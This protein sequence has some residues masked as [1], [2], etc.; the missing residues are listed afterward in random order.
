MTLAALAALFA[1]VGALA[2]EETVKPTQLGE[3]V[4]DDSPA[5][6]AHVV[7][8]TPSYVT[9]YV[10]PIGTHTNEPA[11]QGDIMYTRFFG[12]AGQHRA[13]VGLW[14]SV[15]DGFG[16]EWDAYAGAELATGTHSVLGL[17]V[18]LYNIE[19]VQVVPGTGD[20]IELGVRHLWKSGS[21][22]YGP[23]VRWLQPIDVPLRGAPIIYGEVSW[24]STD[25]APRTTLELRQR[26]GW[27]FGTYGFNQ[28]LL[29]NSRLTVAHAFDQYGATKASAYVDYS[30][31]INGTP[32]RGM[33]ISIGFAFSQSFGF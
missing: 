27:D 26:I 18:L 2:A 28:E 30:G 20:I 6:P 33:Y 11:I 4:A 5:M 1:S 32:P 24:T 16:N 29:S 12:S 8:V 19:P 3:V 10:T 23:G 9:D 21:W 31:A 15:G 14:G 22:A 13:Y 17:D 25:I 7:T